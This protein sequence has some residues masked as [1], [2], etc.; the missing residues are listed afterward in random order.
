MF[1][2]QCDSVEKWIEQWTSSDVYVC[3]IAKIIV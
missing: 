3:I 2:H 1:I